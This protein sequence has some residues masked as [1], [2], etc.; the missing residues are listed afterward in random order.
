VA[1]PVTGIH[2]TAGG[3]AGSHEQKTDSQHF[4]LF[5]SS[6]YRKKLESMLKTVMFRV[7]GFLLKL[8]TLSVTMGCP[9]TALAE[10]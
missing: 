3:K 10:T 9:D 2:R 4:F 5:I 1:G 6:S 8:G 7:K